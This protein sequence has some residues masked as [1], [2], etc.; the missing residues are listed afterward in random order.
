MRLVVIH[1]RLLPIALAFWRDHRRWLLIGAPARLVAGSIPM[2]RHHA[3][4]S[5]G[6]TS[7]GLISLRPPQN[8]LV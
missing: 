8:T 5:P 2:R 3:S 6:R 7:E 1:W 4:Y